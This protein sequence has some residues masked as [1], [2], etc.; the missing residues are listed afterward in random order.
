MYRCR[1][2]WCRWCRWS[3]FRWCLWCWWSWWSWC[4]W[5]MWCRWSRCR[6]CKWC[7]LSC[8]RWSEQL[9]LAAVLGGKAL[10]RSFREKHVQIWKMRFGRLYTVVKQLFSLYHS[11]QCLPSLPCVTSL[12]LSAR[13]NG[14]SKTMLS[15]AFVFASQ[16]GR[17]KYYS[18]WSGH[19]VVNLSVGFKGSITKR[20]TFDKL[21]QKRKEEKRKEEQ[22]S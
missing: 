15:C 13:C 19:F 8:C 18:I 17:V 22:Q 9:N 14:M 10:G 12:A 2:S 5:C 7:G 4:G 11:L 3:R 20:K 6:W 21:E 16:W 1:W